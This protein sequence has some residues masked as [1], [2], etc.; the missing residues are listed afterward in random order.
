LPRIIRGVDSIENGMKQINAAMNSQ[1][2]TNSMVQENV[3]MLK[4]RSEDIKIATGEQK[5]EVYKIT[6]SMNTITHLSDTCSA[7]ADEIASTSEMVAQTAAAL[8]S[9]VSYFKV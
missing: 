5:I 3:I 8:K 1:M 7:G 2:Q 9:S 6:Q 4:S